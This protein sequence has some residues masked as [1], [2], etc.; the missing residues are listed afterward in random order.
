MNTYCVLGIQLS[1]CNTSTHLTFS[2]KICQFYKLSIVLKLL[3]LTNN[4]S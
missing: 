1:I 4:Y 2:G 3:V